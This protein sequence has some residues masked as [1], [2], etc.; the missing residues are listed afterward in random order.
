[1]SLLDEL[2]YSIRTLLKHPGFVITVILILALGIGANSTIFSVVNAVL[3]RPLPYESPDRIV[4]IWETNPSKGV[5]RSIVSPANF[6]D[7]KAQN[8]V[9]DDL[10]A[11]RFWYY[12][13]T[14]GG[15]PQR[16]SGA[17][18]SASFFPLLGIKAALGRTF[19]P[20]E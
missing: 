16:Y 5:K 7:W 14:G 20:D 18:V 13:V 1:M 8:Q 10:A 11:F 15:D 3:L 9:F 17:R 12:T 2:R 6:I 4:M 19:T